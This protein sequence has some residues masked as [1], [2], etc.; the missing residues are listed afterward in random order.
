[1]YQ[2]GFFSAVY[3]FLMVAGSWAATVTYDWDITWVYAAPDGYGRPVIGINGAW[4]CP[5]IEAE[6]GDTVV[7]NVNNQLGNQTTGIHFHGISQAKSTWMDGPSAV[8]QCPVP[9]GSSITYSFLADEPGTFWYHSHNLGQYPDGLRGPMIVHDPND[10]YAGQYDEEVILTV[11]DWYHTQSLYLVQDML[12]TS[13]TQFLPPFPDNILVNEGQGAK[14]D[15]EVNKTYR[16]RIICYSAFASAMLH[17]DSHTMQV[18]MNDA[19]YVT[20]KQAYQLRISPAQRYDVLISGISRDHRNYPF[21]LSLDINRD[22][23]VDAASGI[24]WPHNY[25]GQLVMKPN[26]TFSDDV[27]AKWQPVDDAHFQPYDSLAAYSP[28]TTTITLDFSFCD[29]V[30]GYPRACFNNK[31]YIDQTVPT[32]YTAATVGDNN[33]NPLVYGAVQPYIVDDGEVVELVVNNQDAAIH[34]FH[35]HGHQFQVLDR[36]SS[37][38]GLWSGS[39]R[40][41]PATPPRRDT[42]AVN[43]NSYVVIRFKV[44]NPG[45][46]LF[47]CHI[48]WHVEMGLTVTIIQ[49]PDQLKGL[50]F[51][52]DH[53]ANCKKM[54]IPYQGNAIGNTVDPLNTTGFQTVPSTSYLGCVVPSLVLSPWPLTFPQCDVRINNVNV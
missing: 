42:I 26:G 32:L 37:N 33:T 40:T 41:F 38:T 54:G 47:H 22:Y 20:Q 2:T 12:V 5:K 46:F 27:V 7:V 23:A 35:L 25:T 15:F 3:L 21:L 24:V 53:I 39:S 17:F 48:E 44:Q 34:P 11:S 29:D 1:M 30:N 51:P 28:V 4:P 6:V 50:T 31:T 45:V 8:D 36:P 10:P 52:D 18:I 49:E 9:P 19:S 16:F 14:I 13:N 43:G